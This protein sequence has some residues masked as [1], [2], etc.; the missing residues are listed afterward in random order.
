[1]WISGFH[2]ALRSCDLVCAQEDTVLSCFSHV[3]VFATPW[4]VARQALLSMGFSTG[5]YC[6]GL[7]FPSPGD[8]PDPGIKSESLLS[9]AEFPQCSRKKCPISVFP[10]GTL[11]F[12]KE[13]Q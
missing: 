3:R 11:N 6:S 2:E 9:P 1:M 13:H 12:L 10:E 5:E 7:P 8:L 4:N